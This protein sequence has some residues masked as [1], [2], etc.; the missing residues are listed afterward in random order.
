MRMQ[1]GYLNQ[2]KAPKVMIVK[3]AEAVKTLMILTQLQM[4]MTVTGTLSLE[5]FRQR[6]LSKHWKSRVL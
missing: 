2:K 1:I 3:K 5:N 4:R 6:S